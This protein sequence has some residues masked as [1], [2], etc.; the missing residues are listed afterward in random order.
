[1]LH[2]D[3]ERKLVK[4]LSELELT[5]QRESE[6][7]MQRGDKTFATK[8]VKDWS[9]HS[10][11]ILS[12][13]MCKAEGS[14]LI[15]SGSTD[16]TFKLSNYETGEVVHTFSDVHA[17][18]VLSL[19][20]NPNPALSH[21]LLTGAMDGTASVVD[22]SNNRVVQAFTDH[23]KYVVVAKWHPSGKFFATGSHDHN[24]NVYKFKD[25]ADAKDQSPF[26]LAAQLPFNLNV[27]TIAFTPDG[28]RLY[29]GIR[30]SN[31]LQ[32]F[33]M[34]GFEKTKLNMNAAG[35]DHVSFSALHLSFSPTDHQYLLVGTDRS[36]NILYREGSSEPVR[37]FWGAN[38]DLYSNP[39]CAWHPTGKYV[40]STSQDHT[41]HCWEVANQ[42]NVSKLT[43]HKSTVR[44][45]TF[46]NN[47]NILA[48]CSFD[49]T[50]KIWTA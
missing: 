36:R 42:T 22:T 44:D 41:I 7:L 30:E 21:L 24:V 48:S 46:L 9:P 23:K 25:G 38:N 33:D 3:K 8:C 2:E 5:E 4:Q 17:S 35:D 37:N 31:Y 12:V 43:G 19:D 20:W 14:N 11:N 18:A 26:E 34:N 50:V 32:I 15:A 29:V 40:Y 39:R 1:M 45:L 16:K 49:K 13:S 27:E 10:S 6:A 28:Q 47:K